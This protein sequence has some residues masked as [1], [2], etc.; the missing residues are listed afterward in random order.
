MKID[1][2]KSQSYLACQT[3]LFDDGEGALKSFVGVLD[4]KCGVGRLEKREAWG[5]ACQ[6]RRSRSKMARANV[7]TRQTKP[8][9][10]VGFSK[11]AR[12]A[13]EQKMR[14]QKSDAEAVVTREA[15]AQICV[16]DGGL[17]CLAEAV[18]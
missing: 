2:E 4:K 7:H 9:Q 11:R 5:S 12:N 15:S 3:E 14:R 18:V 1:L 16:D 8:S 17:T 13:R 10:S 6:G